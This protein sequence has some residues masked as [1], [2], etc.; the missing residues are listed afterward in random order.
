LFVKNL[1][2]R[3]TQRNLVAKT[4]RFSWLL[5]FVF[6]TFF[7]PQPTFVFFFVI[8]AFSLYRNW[9]KTIS[10]LFIY[11]A[12]FCWRVRTSVD[13]FKYARCKVSEASPVTL[14]ETTEIGDKQ[15][16]VFVTCLRVNDTPPME[17]QI[18]YNTTLSRFRDLFHC[19]S[20]PCFLWTRKT[21]RKLTISPTTDTT[22]PV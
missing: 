12:T 18:F 15:L 5:I 16:Q 10:L 8:D 4:Y 13:Y 14:T 11:Y 6:V 9:R 1:N 3:P 20:T 2:S 21:V 7:S 19:T 22:Y 17:V